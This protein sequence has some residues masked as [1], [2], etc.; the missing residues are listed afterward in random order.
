MMLKWLLR[1]HDIVRMVR[2]SMSQHHILIS[3]GSNVDREYYTQ[4]GITAL[5]ERLTDIHLSSTYES[6][7]VG[8]SGAAFYNLVMSAYTD[9]SIA[10][11]VRFFK[12]IEHKNGRT[13]ADI[14]FAP[15]TL[16]IDLLTYDDVVCVEPVVL[17]RP[18]IEYHA[19]VLAPLAELLPNKLHPS[20]QMSYAQMWAEFEQP[21]QK[22][23]TID[24]TWS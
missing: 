12:D 13:R 6:E 10:E 22:L 21:E 11:V 14:K 20:T 2:N 4:A 16:D 18:E 9:M 19:F 23:W 1:S 3:L 15:R 5:T 24:I 8:F 17:P 7:A